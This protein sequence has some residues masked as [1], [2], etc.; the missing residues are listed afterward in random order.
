MTT[1]TGECPVCRSMN[2]YRSICGD[3]GQS[4]QF[5]S[6]EDAARFGEVNN[7]ERDNLE[8]VEAVPASCTCYVADLD[9]EAQFGL[10][11]G[12]HGLECPRFNR[13]LDPVD[14]ANDQEFRATHS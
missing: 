10:R 5:M 12:A 9:A 13:S 2:S 1:Q 11:W 4:W 14:D 8:H 6:K 7:D 3:C